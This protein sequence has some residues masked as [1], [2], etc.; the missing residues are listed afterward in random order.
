MLTEIPCEPNVKREFHT[1]T[2][3]FL[4][5]FVLSSSI[6]LFTLK[7]GIKVQVRVTTSHLNFVK[8]TAGAGQ[9]VNAWSSA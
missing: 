3:K 8:V 9:G 6:F 7:H 4:R 1:H 2:I 5:R